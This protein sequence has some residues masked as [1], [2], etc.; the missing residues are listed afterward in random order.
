LGCRPRLLRGPVVVDELNLEIIIIINGISTVPAGCP[1][2]SR[3]IDPLRPAPRRRR[4]TSV[5]PRWAP[6]RMPA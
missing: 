2:T 6:P 1:L 5:E 4:A 3:L